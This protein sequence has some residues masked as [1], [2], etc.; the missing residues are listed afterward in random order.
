[1]TNT[2]SRFVH[3]IADHFVRSMVLGIVAGGLYGLLISLTSDSS[4]FNYDPIIDCGMYGGFGAVVAWLIAKF[5]APIVPAPNAEQSERKSWEEIVYP[6]FLIRNKGE[7]HSPL[8]IL[9]RKRN[10]CGIGIVLVSITTLIQM[11]GAPNPIFPLLGGGAF[12]GI[13]LLGLV[14]TSKKTSRLS[15][16]SKVSLDHDID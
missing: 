16:E 1:M 5:L 10:L 3:F 6:K 4:Y 7:I 9:K 13:L 14:F 2:I 11:V 8:E 12:V 15:N